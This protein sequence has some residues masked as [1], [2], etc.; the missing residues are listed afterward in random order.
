M[1][2]VLQAN[3]GTEKTQYPTLYIV[4]GCCVLFAFVS[5]IIISGFEDSM[6]PGVTHALAAPFKGFWEGTLAII[7]GVGVGAATSAKSLL[8][9][10]SSAFSG[11]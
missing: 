7:Q 8:S 2:T 11:Y 10:S 5:V 6:T 9:A 3:T 1:A 4:A